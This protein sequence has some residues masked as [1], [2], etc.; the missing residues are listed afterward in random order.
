MTKEIELAPT[1]ELI[2]VTKAINFEPGTIEVIGADKLVAA[3]KQEALKYKGLVV[4]SETKSSVSKKRTELNKY[5]KGIEAK[6]KEIHAEFEKPYKEFEDQLSQIK[7]P[8]EETI[9]EIKGGLDLLKAA[10][11][12][13]RELLTDELIATAAER[14]DMNPDDIVR[15]SEWDNLGN[16]PSEIERARAIEQAFKDAEQG[17]KWRLAQ[18]KA[19]TDYCAEKHIDPSGWLVS[20]QNYDYATEKVMQAIDEAQEE[21]HK[22]QVAE[23]VD[24]ETGE[25]VRRDMVLRIMDLDDDQLASIQMYLSINGIKFEEVEA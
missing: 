23:S 5:V 2:D 8:L 1:E 6:R 16:K 24:K 11:V 25:I 17:K 20:L 9:G 3:A 7:A 21:K 13:E 22:Q 12:A 18:M 14:H 4:T 15:Q 19:I 10:Q